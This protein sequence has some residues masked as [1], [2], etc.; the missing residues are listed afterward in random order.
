MDRSP[1]SVGSGKDEAGA[2]DLGRGLV[3]SE[4][5]QSLI[6]G[7]LKQAVAAVPGPSV[8]SIRRL[9]RAETGQ[10]VRAEGEREIL[11]LTQVAPAGDQNE[12]PGAALRVA[13]CQEYMP[14]P[15]GGGLCCLLF[16]E[17]RLE[18]L[19]R[20]QLPKNANPQDRPHRSQGRAQIGSLYCERVAFRVES[21]VQDL[22]RRGRRIRISS[23]DRRPVAV[24]VQ[25]VDKSSSLDEREHQNFLQESWRSIKSFYPN[26]PN[27]GL[28]APCFTLVGERPDPLFLNKVRVTLDQRGQRQPGIT[29]SRAGDRATRNSAVDAE[30]LRPQRVGI[31][32]YVCQ[33]RRWVEDGRV[34]QGEL[35]ELFV[36]GTGEMIRPL[37]GEGFVERRQIE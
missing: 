1:S 33:C 32:A 14:S 7:P 5:P 17:V 21:R 35:A 23:I 20:Q 3:R 4:D 15:A 22:L 19:A 31:G 2:H 16:R 27:R 29:G 34:G 25:L 11:G 36:I 12:Q 28:E 13:K 18:H 6:R 26:L 30:M 10:A 8:A 37:A 24:Q 9:A